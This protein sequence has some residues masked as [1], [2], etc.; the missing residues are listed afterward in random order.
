MKYLWISI[1]S[2]IFATAVFAAPQS[3]FTI[4]PAGAAVG[5]TVSLQAL[6]YNAEKTAITYTI[7][8]TNQEKV[9]HTQTTSIPSLGAKTIKTSFIVPKEPTTITATI[10]KA[11]TPKGIRV[12]GLEKPIGTL[13]IGPAAPTKTTKFLE[14]VEK[15]VIVGK[16]YTYL[17]TFRTTQLVSMT[18]IRDGAKLRVG[19]SIEDVTKGIIAK[20]IEPALT[21]TAVPDTQKETQTAGGILDYVTY[22]ASAALVQLLV[23]QTAF[24]VAIGVLFLLVLRIV[25]RRIF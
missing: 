24:F 1:T 21:G 19:S 25:F 13:V 6:V 16:L 10:Q 23:N 7:A 9:V 12:G 8:F 15:T 18:A 22:I 4:E 11:V 14:S 20:N 3:T 17:D 5:S 2:L